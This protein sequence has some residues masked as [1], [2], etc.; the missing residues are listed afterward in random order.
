VGLASSKAAGGGRARDSGPRLPPLGEP[1]I[2]YRLE[3]IR[4]AARA[5]PSSLSLSPPIHTHGQEEKGG[6]Q[7]EP[8]AWVRHHL[9][10]QQAARAGA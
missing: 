3:K 6:A 1:C 8:R 5:S 2:S 7:A 4:I 10:A 9:G